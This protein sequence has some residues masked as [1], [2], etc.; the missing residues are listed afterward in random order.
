[1][2]SAQQEQRDR[3]ELLVLLG[4]REDRESLVQL[5][6]PEH[7]GQLEV[8]ESLD[9]REFLGRKVVLDQPVSQGRKGQQVML[10]SLVQ[11]GQSDNAVPRVPQVSKDR[12]ALQ[13]VKD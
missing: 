5:A 7:L 1:V 9:L 2:R 8:L 10:G 6:Q 13:E 11:V 12:L 4:H 3:S